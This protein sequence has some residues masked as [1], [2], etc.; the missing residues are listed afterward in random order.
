MKIKVKDLKDLLRDDLTLAERGLLLTILLLKDSDPKLTLAKVKAKV[1]FKNTRT[2]LIKLHE[3]NLIEW[4][5][6]KA[7]K[8]LES[9]KSVNPDVIEAV[10]FMNALYKRSFSP[11]AASTITS[12]TQRIKEYGLEDVKR[13]ISNRYTVWK[14]DPVMNVHLNPTTI[15]RLSKFQK[16]LEEAKRT[17]KGSAILQADKTNLKNGQEITLEVAETLLDDEVYSVKIHKVSKK[18]VVS[19]IGQDSKDYG[20]DIRKTLMIRDRQVRFGGDKEFIYIYQAN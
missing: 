8:K 18:G 6:Y 20:K 14:D 12:L 1:N 2:E 17:Q 9:D 19:G 4:S 16:Y 7:A 3:K 11:T 10:S 5:G 13:V 15:F